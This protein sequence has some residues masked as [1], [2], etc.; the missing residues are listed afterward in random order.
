MPL[1]GVAADKVIAAAR[2]FAARGDLGL[3]IPAHEMH[4]NGGGLVLL[5]NFLFIFANSR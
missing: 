3:R 2:Q 1:A 5:V 4:V